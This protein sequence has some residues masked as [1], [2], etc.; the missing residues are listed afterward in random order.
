MTK[1]IEKIIEEKE[2]TI[3]FQRE[4]FFGYFFVSIFL[5]SIGFFLTVSFPVLNFMGVII[6]LVTYM[7]PTLIGFDLLSSYQDKFD[8]PKLIHPKRWMILVLNVTLG[9]TIFFWIYSLYV[10]CYPGKILATIVRYESK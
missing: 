9:W 4:L 3:F 8:I 10:S 2:L 6:I 7:M 5:I 1:K